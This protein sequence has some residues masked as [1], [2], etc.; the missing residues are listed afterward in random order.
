MSNELEQYVAKSYM[1]ALEEV[2]SIELKGSDEDIMGALD[3]MAKV[4]QQRLGNGVTQY[5]K[6]LQLSHL[7]KKAQAPKF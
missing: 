6:Q 1:K 2:G 5:I 4:N 7:T 3:M